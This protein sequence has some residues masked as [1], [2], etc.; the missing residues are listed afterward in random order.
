MKGSNKINVLLTKTLVSSY[1]GPYF[2]K[3]Y[4]DEN[5]CP[6]VIGNLQNDLSN[7]VQ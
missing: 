7:D 5:I 2:S 6:E 3:D 4:F 1:N